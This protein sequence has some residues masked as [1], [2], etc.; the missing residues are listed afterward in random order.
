MMYFVIYKYEN[1]FT[2]Y[3]NEIFETEKEA[4]EF[5][6]KSLSKKDEWRVVE[7]NKDNFDKY[8]YR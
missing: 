8:W 2:K 1:N 3:T 4:K 7:Y 5:A 6:K